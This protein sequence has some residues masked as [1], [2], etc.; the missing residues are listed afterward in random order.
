MK[1]KVLSVVL[2]VAAVSATTAFARGTKD[3]TTPGPWAR[4]WRGPDVSEKKTEVTG[5]LSLEDW[6][7]VLKTDTEE[8]ALMV[9]GRYRY[10][11][12]VKQGDTVKAEGYLVENAPWCRDENEKALLVTKA[13]VNGKEYQIDEGG[14]G[15]MAMGPGG[16]GMG[17]WYGRPYGGMMRGPGMM[18]RAWGPGPGPS[19]SR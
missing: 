17:Q 2:L 5:K 10:D 16:R 3:D 19:G 8:Y 4:G 13:V 14:W 7:P 11:I 18:G 15:P 9:P 6:H 1:A 12:D